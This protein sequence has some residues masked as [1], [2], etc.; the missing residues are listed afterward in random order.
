MLRITILHPLEATTSIEIEELDVDTIL[1]GIEELFADVELCTHCIPDD[2]RFS[3]EHFIFAHIRRNSRSSFEYHFAQDFGG[4][5]R[6]FPT[7]SNCLT[8]FI[9]ELIKRIGVKKQ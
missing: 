4:S 7:M 9:P 8:E 6:Y 5:Y 1:N 3:N 2:V